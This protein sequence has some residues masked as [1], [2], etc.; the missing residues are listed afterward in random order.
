MTPGSA[1]TNTGLSFSRTAN[2]EPLRR[3]IRETFPNE[4]IKVQSSRDSLALTGRVSSAQVSER[5]LVV[6]A[7]SL[8]RD[9][10]DVAERR[11][12][13]LR[14]RLRDDHHG[15]FSLPANPIAHSP[16]RRVSPT[17]HS[18]TSISTKASAIKTPDTA[19][20]RASSVASIARDCVFFPVK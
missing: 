19:A 20:T 17:V 16:M 3:L 2:M 4:D 13:L 8:G 15:R 14:E 18:M 1:K 12:R 5:V 6:G 9:V 10:D 11:E 7:A